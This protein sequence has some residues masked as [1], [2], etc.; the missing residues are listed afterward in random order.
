[1]AQYENEFPARVRVSGHL[2]T[3]IRSIGHLRIKVRR[4]L[5]LKLETHPRTEQFKSHSTLIILVTV[6]I[7]I[8]WK[9]KNDPFFE[10][11]QALLQPIIKNIMMNLGLGTTAAVRVYLY[12]CESG[13]ATGCVHRESNLI[14][15]LSSDKDQRRN[16]LSLS[17]NDP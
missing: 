12:W 9:S 13:I 15:T 6:N 17:V 14:F 3:L 1:M 2:R 4:C 16:S 5:V 10:R 11:T 7:F 8:R